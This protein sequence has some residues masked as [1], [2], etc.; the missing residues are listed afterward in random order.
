MRFVVGIGLAALAMT[1]SAR[2]AETITYS[3]DA[4]GRLVKVERSGGV[5]NGVS[6]EY[7]HDKA[8]NRKKLKVTGSPNPAP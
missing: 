5:N 2:A 4:K 6:A 8:D 3:Y 1:T 7:T